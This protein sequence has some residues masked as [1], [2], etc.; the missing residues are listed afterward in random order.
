MTRASASSSEENNSGTAEGKRESGAVR[1]RFEEHGEKVVVRENVFD[2]LKSKG[3]VEVLELY[4]SWTF[5][6]LKDSGGALRGGTECSCRR[7]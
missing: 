4:E 6:A 1:E 3:L 5:S 2:Q 7:D